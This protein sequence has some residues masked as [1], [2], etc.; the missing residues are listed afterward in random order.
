MCP[1]NR[2]KCKYSNKSKE[3]KE[4]W[5]SLFF[6]ALE[7]LAFLANKKYLPKDLASFYKD[8]FI[9]YYDKIFKIHAPKEQIENPK[10]FEEIKKLYNFLKKSN[11]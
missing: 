9:D 3:E 4:N 7:R 11:P 6:N 10:K 2:G 1:L 5:Q 8:A